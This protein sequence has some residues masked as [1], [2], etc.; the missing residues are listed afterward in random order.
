MIFLII[1][2]LVAPQAYAA[3]DS[4]HRFEK[5]R[6]D[7]DLT[8][9]GERR[10]YVFEEQLVCFDAVQGGAESG[11]L[12]APDGHPFVPL[13]RAHREGTE[14]VLAFSPCSVTFYKFPNFVGPPP[15][16]PREPGVA[17]DEFNMLIPIEGG[18]VRTRFHPGGDKDSFSLG[19]AG[20]HGKT[21]PDSCLHRLSG[22]PLDDPPSL[23][24]SINDLL[25]RSLEPMVAKLAKSSPRLSDLRNACGHIEGLEGIFPPEATQPKGASKAPPPPPAPE[26]PVDDGPPAPPAPKEKTVD[27]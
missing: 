9:C 2:A 20:G 16:C 27:F 19:A 1:W 18:A 7:L 23:V 8:G 6:N 26:P 11:Y 25:K 13:A 17:A 24:P 10:P 4:A 15:G 5:A 14:G 21:L 3:E 22:E 12:V